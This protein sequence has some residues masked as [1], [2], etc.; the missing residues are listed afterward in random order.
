MT[1]SMIS[2]FQIEWAHNP[3]WIFAA[4]LLAGLLTWHLYDRY[5]HFSEIAPWK[6]WIM[7]ALRFILWASLLTLLLSP[8]VKSYSD[9][10]QRKTIAVLLDKSA[11][12]SH[13][14]DSAA[15]KNAMNSIVNWTE[16]LADDVDVVIYD[17][18]DD[19]R[20]HQDNA[21][22]SGLRTNY[23]STLKSVKE[24]VSP[25]DLSAIIFMTD[26]IYNEGGH[27]LYM[28]GIEQT[29]IYPLFVGDTTAK[30]DIGI[31]RVLK[32]QVV[33]KDDLFTIEVDVKCIE[34]PNRTIKV[35]LQEKKGDRYYDLS[36]QNIEVNKRNFFKTLPFQIN[37][38]HAGLI[39]YRVVTTVIDGEK[40]QSNNIKAFF[41]DVI[42]SKQHI[43]IIANAPHPDVEAIKA[44]MTEQKNYSVDIQYAR[45]KNIDF[46][47]SDLVIFHNLPSEKYPI[48]SLLNQ[49]VQYQRPALFI[50]G[51]MTDLQLFNNAQ[52]LM[53]IVSKGNRQYEDAEPRIADHINQFKLNEDIKSASKRW[54]PLRSPFASYQSQTDNSV[55][56]Y[57]DI[58]GISTDHPMLVLSTDHAQKSGIIVGE[59]I[60]KWRLF[61]YVQ[62]GHFDHVNEFISQI[63]QYLAISADRRRF[64]VN[65]DQ[66]IYDEDQRVQFTAE[67]YNPS[68]ELTNSA[69][70][71]MTLTNGEGQESKFTFSRIEDF[72]ELDLGLLSPDHYRYRAITNVQGQ[73]YTSNGEFTV[74]PLIEEIQEL[75]ANHLLLQN[76]A[77]KSGGSVYTT[78]Q[79]AAL[80]SDIREHNLLKPTYISELRQQS[81]LN[82]TWILVLLLAI[83]SLE[84]FLR[85]Y[86]G[87]Y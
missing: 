18:D 22:F 86:Y 51:T 19:I 64:K 28:K 5:E 33:Y 32:N 17:F 4:T 75:T 78:E 11:S 50:V 85:K 54:P 10:I 59:N 74:Q 41:V 31:Q 56:M 9:Q 82:W 46:Q 72:Y 29:P 42:E 66:H 70:V 7:S 24:S 80:E 44:I 23:I 76:L 79:L 35:T 62:N 16:S 2:M 69:D 48:A 38:D 47:K 26:G 71:E 77:S 57:Q 12:I 30:M 60:W 13:G 15:M 65:M 1:A 43:T 61:D 63:I 68:Y 81:I 20:P 87:S 55:L 45:D 83:L 34:V 39:P 84:W 52:D 40:N 58:K 8:V 53:N 21:P 73:S 3:Y 49:M 6:R 67:Y 25:E 27:P 37:A 14:V 36:H